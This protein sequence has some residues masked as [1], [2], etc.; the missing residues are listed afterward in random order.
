MQKLVEDAELSNT[1]VVIGL[2]CGLL[3][4][5][6]VTVKDG[7]VALKEGHDTYYFDITQSSYVKKTS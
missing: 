1:P 3:K 4:T 6:T 2:K 7:L 5:G